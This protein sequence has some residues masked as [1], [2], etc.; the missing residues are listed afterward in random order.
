MYS[1]KC[2]N[3]LVW[4]YYR[5]PLQPVDE[6]TVDEETVTSEQKEGPFYLSMYIQIHDFKKRNATIQDE[7][8][9]NTKWRGQTMLTWLK[10]QRSRQTEHRAW[11]PVGWQLITLHLWRRKRPV[12]LSQNTLQGRSQLKVDRQEPGFQ[13]HSISFRKNYWLQTVWLAT[14]PSGTYMAN[15]FFK[16]SVRKLSC[17]HKTWF[18]RHFIVCFQCALF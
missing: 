14:H 12:Q 9:L 18:S 13:V 2:H 3:H 8:S 11:L 17:K 1:F 15:F 4:E 10:A 5:T 7:K 16:F 6:N